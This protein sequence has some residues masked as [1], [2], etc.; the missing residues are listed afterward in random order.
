[1]NDSPS[2]FTC[3]NCEALLDDYIDGTL[4]A[5]R[6][7]ALEAHLEDCPACLEESQEIRRIVE[8]AAALPRSL[9]P[10]EDLL[11]EIHRRMAELERPSW[12]VPEW[13]KHSL[14][15]LLLVGLGALL[16]RAFWQPV[17]V[18]SD[19]GQADLS[20]PGPVSDFVVAEAQLIDTQQ[21]LR[22]LI[23]SR[24][25]ELSP[26]TLRLVERNLRIIDEA[27]AELRQ[28]LELEPGNPQI[29]ERLLAQHRMQISL[30]RRLSSP[31]DLL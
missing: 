27:T 2:K 6:A 11:P 9:P 31:G 1:M 10:P 28:A 22:L 23:E 13:L 7:A 29:E 26:S 14:A 17:A 25:Q 19:L 16:A 18:S 4:D 15:A 30:L 3:D 12:A 21:D 5:A 20:A 8:A 24:R